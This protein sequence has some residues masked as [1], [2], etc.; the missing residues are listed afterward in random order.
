MEPRAW[1]TTHPALVCLAG[2]P[3]CP[4]DDDEIGPRF[5]CNPEHLGIDARSGNDE[6]TGIE[7]GGIDRRIRAASRFASS[8]TISS[9]PSFAVFVWR[10]ASTLRINSEDTKPGTE[11]AC[12]L[13]GGEEWLAA[14]RL[15][16]EVNW[17]PEYLYMLA[18]R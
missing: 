13:D 5:L 11:P 9:Y 7:V 6:K 17:P 8:E 18:S 4:P 15:V 10:M 14:G 2:N 16:I 3:S 12:E 1:R